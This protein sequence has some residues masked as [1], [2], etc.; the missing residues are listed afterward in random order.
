MAKPLRDLLSEVE[1][2][3]T[4]IR[5]LSALRADC[6]TTKHNCES[7]YEDCL[8]GDHFQ[9]KSTQTFLRAAEDWA[10]RGDFADGEHYGEPMLRRVATMLYVGKYLLREDAPRR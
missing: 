5:F 10:R 6:E 8:E 7:R 1:D 2:E 4:F 3:T 9:T